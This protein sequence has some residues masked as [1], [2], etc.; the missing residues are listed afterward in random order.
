MCEPPFVIIL[1]MHAVTKD[2]KSSAAT[3]AAGGV[4]T[5]SKD[6]AAKSAAKSVTVAGHSNVSGFRGASNVAAASVYDYPENSDEDLGAVHDWDFS[7]DIRELKLAPFAAADPKVVASSKALALAAA[8]SDEEWKSPAEE[9]SE[10]EEWK[11]SAEESSEDEE[12]NE[13]DHASR[14]IP[15]PP[16]PLPPH[17]AGLAPARP[18]ARAPQPPSIAPKYSTGTGNRSVA[19]PGARLSSGGVASGNKRRRSPLVSSKVVGPI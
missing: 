16:P 8:T 7:V 10:D 5:G 15:P 6:A 1:M 12:E 13:D 2:L 3:D 19:S 14:R 11:S 9:S 18:A 17:A 4:S